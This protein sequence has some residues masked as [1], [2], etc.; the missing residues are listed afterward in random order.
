MVRAGLQFCR[1]TLF[2]KV[3]RSSTCLIYHG[4]GPIHA[5]TLH[6]CEG[7]QS[8]F[9]LDWIFRHK[10][11]SGY[12]CSYKRQKLCKANCAAPSHGQD[13]QNAW[14]LQF[15]Y[16]TFPMMLV[17]RRTLI[18]YCFYLLACTLSKKPSTSFRKST[19]GWQLPQWGGISSDELDTQQAIK[20]ILFISMELFNEH[21]LLISTLQD[22]Y[23][24]L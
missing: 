10:R 6:N 22:E 3:T 13:L 7:A 12:S 4:E 5:M 11:L 8:L 24:P 19:W 17:F 2:R 14:L 18:P 20:I 15:K 16:F 1:P 9:D 23:L 21:S